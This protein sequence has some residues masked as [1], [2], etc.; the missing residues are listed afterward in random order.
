MD[1]QITGS[2]KPGKK[3]RESHGIEDREAQVRVTTSGAVSR[4]AHT[5][6]MAMGEVKMEMQC[7]AEK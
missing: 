5:V 7:T 6:K 4:M 1:Q 2:A 3:D